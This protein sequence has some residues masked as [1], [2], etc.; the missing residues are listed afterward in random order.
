MS[1]TKN[2]E[3]Y[4]EIAVEIGKRLINEAIWNDRRCTWTGDNMEM[5][6]NDWKIVHGVVDESLYSGT[7]GIALFLAQLW[8]ATGNDEFRVTAE[9]AIRQTFARIKMENSE[10]SVGF[11]NGLMG[12]AWG[13]VQIGNIFS[14]NSLIG[15]GFQLASGVCHEFNNNWDNRQTDLIDGIAGVLIGLIY[16]YKIKED[17]SFLKTSRKIANQ[18]LK[19]AT[20]TVAGWSW[21]QQCVSSESVHLC[22][23]GHGA[24]GIAYSLM[25]FYATTGEEEFRKAAFE[26]IRYEKG[27]F[28]RFRSNWPDIRDSSG[29]KRTA[30][31]SLAY[32]VYWCHGAAGIGMVRFRLYQLTKDRTMLAEAGAAI[33]AANAFMRNLSQKLRSQ[34]PGEEL[35]DSNFS[36]CHGL[37]SIVDL[38]A[39]AYQVTG[40]KEYLHRARR[41]GDIGIKYCSTHS[42]HW[43]CG[44]PGGGEN[45][46]LMIGLAGIG[47]CYLRLFD[48]DLTPPIGILDEKISCPSV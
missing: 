17:L 33:Q 47:S 34:T 13:T 26:A 38:F 32:P 44:I 7:S 2:S 30:A 27:W 22:G 9:G 3:F 18:L 41:I 36:A 1:N 6:G 46:G 14:S 20:K 45:P 25:E 48:P 16:L 24:S 12:I 5:V 8:R 11:F 28:N 4:R 31:D 10:H 35:Y 43:L 21:G 37:G 39:Y 42:G 19:S 15:E 40:L 29:N 23:M